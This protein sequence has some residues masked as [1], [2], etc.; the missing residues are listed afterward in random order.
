[1]E[2]AKLWIDLLDDAKARKMSDQLFRIFI[3]FLLA[4]KEIDENGY[5]GEP[6][7]LAWRIRISSGD[8][9]S[10]LEA[11]SEET[12][13]ITE[14]RADGWYVKNYDKRQQSKDKTAAERTRRYRER[15]AISGSQVN[16]GYS[17]RDIKNRDGN[18]CVYCG[19]DKNLCV[20]HMIPVIQGGTDDPRNLATACKKCNSGKSGRTPEEA[21]YKIINPGVYKAYKEYVTVTR[22]Y[23]EEEEEEDKEKEE[24]YSGG[25]NIFKQYESCIGIITPVMADKLKLA[26]QEYSA[27]WITKAFEIAVE[28][29]ARNWSYVHA[30]LERWKTSGFDDGK[31]P[32]KNGKN[33]IDRTSE[34]ARN[35]Y[36]E[37]EK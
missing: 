14:Q 23:A 29:N 17:S 16:A 37:W 1:M 9:L 18:K 5:L 20:D 3:Y 8:C 15:R 25:G 22:H 7:D 10:S 30:I 34:E 27:E 19:S 32:R 28:K 26:E 21:G 13:A 24:E 6:D 12:Y 2:W 36:S 11:L 33:D 4:A 31:K 35:K